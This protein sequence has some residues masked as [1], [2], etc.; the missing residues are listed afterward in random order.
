MP[1]GRLVLSLEP[2]RKQMI[3]S[4]GGAVFHAHQPHTRRM[5]QMVSRRSANRAPFGRLRNGDDYKNL[6]YGFSSERGDKP[7][8]R[9]LLGI[10]R[11]LCREG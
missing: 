7:P 5:G 8:L 9:S 6:I 4:V 2:P 10:E 11:L 1:F 3:S